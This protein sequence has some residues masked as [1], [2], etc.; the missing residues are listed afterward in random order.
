M[1]IDNELLP[2]TSIRVRRGWAALRFD[3][4]WDYR[5]VLV[6]LAFRDIKLRYKQTA[7]GVIWVILQPLLAGAVFAVV[8]GHFAKMP[9]GDKPYLL[10]VFASLLGWNL[11]SA[12]LQR[13]GNSLIK[14]SGLISKVYFPRLLI[15]LA[16]AFS[17]FVDFLVSLTVMAV[18]LCFYKSWPGAW[19]LLFPFVLITALALAIGASFWVAALNIRYRDFTYAMPF[20]MQVLM[21]GS[22][23]VYGLELIP[24]QWRWLFEL[25]PLTGIVEGFRAAFLGGYSGIFKQLAIAGGMGLVVFISG[26]FFFRRVEK[27]FADNL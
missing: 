22:P 8:F 12:I 9:S 25:N 17:A 24:K 10:F 19:L 6:M 27:D 26:A 14:E 15:P 11:F 18:L 4:L 3:E 20:L 2:V 21:Y 23:V 7:L 16:A 1:P 5:D 13:S